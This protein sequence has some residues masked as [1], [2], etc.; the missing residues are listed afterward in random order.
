MLTR[1]TYRSGRSRIL[2]VSQH[3]FFGAEADDSNL[4]PLVF[5]LLRIR[6]VFHRKPYLH[7]VHNAS[8]RET[9][10]CH[11]LRK[12][13]LQTLRSKP[14]T[15]G[16]AQT[17]PRDQFSWIGCVQPSRVRHGPFPH[18]CR[19]HNRRVQGCPCPE[20]WHVNGRLHKETP[21]GTP[22][23][24]FPIRHSRDTCCMPNGFGTRCTYWGRGAPGGG[25]PSGNVPSLRAPSR[26]ECH[27]PPGAKEHRW[28]SGHRD[29]S[30][31]TSFPRRRCTPCC[32]RE[33]EFA[34]RVRG[35]LDIRQ[36]LSANANPAPPPL[37]EKA[38]HRWG[39]A[40]NQFED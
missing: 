1:E 36:R 13:R 4:R 11:N 39:H 40:N 5:L 3:C 33:W 12:R 34:L 24:R 18:R 16:P 21:R 14:A 20:S 27:I 23:H 17:K 35:W 37:P 15:T 9:S 25:G 7:D 8:T 38:G 29:Q 10:C 22:D 32:S 26:C 2:A 30:R 31:T 6:I 19:I 28:S